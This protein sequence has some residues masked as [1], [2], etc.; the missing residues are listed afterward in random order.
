M[1]CS[2]NKA[3]RVKSF[4]ENTNFVC[5][6]IFC[7]PCRFCLVIAAVLVPYESRTQILNKLFVLSLAVAKILK[8]LIECKTYCLCV[9]A[10]IVCGWQNEEGKKLMD[11]SKVLCF[12]C[13]SN[14]I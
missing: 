7:W 6:T 3:A 4:N 8:K 10:W 5:T 1:R 14:E 12:R 11:Y 13:D 9:Y 2:I